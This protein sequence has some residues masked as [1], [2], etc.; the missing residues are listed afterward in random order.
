M[1]HLCFSKLV[2]LISCCIQIDAGNVFYLRETHEKQ[3]LTI[4]CFTQ[5]H[6]MMVNLH[7]E[8][9]RPNLCGEGSEVHGL[10][11]VR[12]T[13]QLVFIF[14]AQDGDGGQSDVCFIKVILDLVCIL[15][16]TIREGGFNINMCLKPRRMC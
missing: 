10:R 3:R 12:K 8:V 14:R 13:F 1:T 2:K 15:R 7:K 16:V 6:F 11:F 9:R 5:I 4:P